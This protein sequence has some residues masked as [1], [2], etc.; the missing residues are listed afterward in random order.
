[1]RAASRPEPVREACE[2]LLVDG[3]QYLDNRPL[4]D[5][6]LQGGNAERALAP[7]W[8]RYVHPPRRT[9]PV[10]A[11]LDSSVQVYEVGSKIL[12]VGVPRHLVHPCCSLRVDRRVGRPETFEVDVVKQCGELRVLVPFW[13]FT[14]TVQR[15]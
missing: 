4:D 10:G 11:A 9:R 1:M 13:D 5:L 12:S 3:V 2:I 7:V 8:L 15:I 14:H 6:V